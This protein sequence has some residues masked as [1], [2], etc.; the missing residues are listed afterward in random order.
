VKFDKS[1]FVD[2]KYTKWYFRLVENRLK[3]PITD[4]YCEWHHIIPQCD[5]FGG[6]DD[7]ENF[8]HFNGQEHLIAHI[9]L[10]KMLPDKTEQQRDML[11]AVWRM[12]IS[13]ELGDG[14]ERY[15]ITGRRYEEI[16][17]RRAKAMTIHFEDW[18]IEAIVV[19]FR[20]NRKS[21]P[22]IHKE[23]GFTYS[24]TRNKLIDVL[25]E[26]EY[27]IIAKRNARINMTDKRSVWIDP[28]IFEM[29][30][31]VFMSGVSIHRIAK[32]YQF[33]S[34]VV[35]RRLVKHF[36]KTKFAE[37]IAVNAEKRKLKYRLPEEII[38]DFL[39]G[40]GITKLH[41]KYSMSPG[42]LAYGLDRDLG[43]EKYQKQTSL[44]GGYRIG[45]TGKRG[46]GEG[47]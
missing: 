10:V 40:L 9:L 34:A 8:V 41:K 17:E 5:S 29:M 20:D 42:I 22:D 43:T 4:R 21:I 46:G 30:C 19:D 12:A 31:K 47:R 25:G 16:R 18:E 45:K 15:R 38:N 28:D 11:D 27:K 26:K 24:V 39:S 3:N 6:S 23:Y 14:I 2:N 36:G 7:D 35:Y 33:S 44:N 1:Q 37:F 32:D 13:P